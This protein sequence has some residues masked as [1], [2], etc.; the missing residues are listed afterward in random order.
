M[1]W[2][3]PKEI[4]PTFS[5]KTTEYTFNIRRT[6]YSKNYKRQ[7]KITLILSSNLQSN[8][9]FVYCTIFCFSLVYRSIGFV[10]VKRCAAKNHYNYIKN[11][12]RAFNSSAFFI[13]LI[14]YRIAGRQKQYNS[15]LLLTFTVRHENIKL[16]PA[17][18][19]IALLPKN[20]KR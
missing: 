4:M 11:N 1:Q 20:K 17:Y 6:I 14:F 3:L 18:A 5:E 8:V 12:N 13:R 19:P 7:N 9:D 15:V 16:S 10:K 2:K